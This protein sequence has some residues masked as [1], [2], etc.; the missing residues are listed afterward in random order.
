MHAL[1]YTR[2]WTRAFFWKYDNFS[3]GG[4]LRVDETPTYNIVS[5][6][7]TN[8]HIICPIIYPLHKTL[9]SF[10][11]S[12]CPPHS[13]ADFLCICAKNIILDWASSYSNLLNIVSNLL[14][15][16]FDV[17]TQ[18]LHEVI[19]TSLSPFETL[20]AKA[21]KSSNFRIWWL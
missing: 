12:N 9:C 8:M 15:T 2:S 14:L 10:L 3:L 21:I 5:P 19:C 6:I 1:C 18:C 13:H 16:L 11:W 4:V 17:Y 20:I 7:A